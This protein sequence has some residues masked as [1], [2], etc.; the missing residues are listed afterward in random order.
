[1]RANA[2]LWLFFAVSNLF[3]Q[4]LGECFP[5][6]ATTP[7]RSTIYLLCENGIVLRRGETGDWETI[8]IPLASR[9]R[10]VHFVTPDR[11]FVTGDSGFAAETADGG[12][13]WRRMA[14]DTRENLT[15][16][17][18]I[19]DRIWIAGFGGVVFHSADDGKTWQ[20][21]RTFVTRPIE[22]LYFVDESRGWAVG[23][24]GLLLRTTDGGNSWQQVNV[25]GLWETLSAI[26]F[27]DHQ[28][29]WA[30]GMNGVMLRTRDG[31]ASWQR[32]PVATRSWLT[33]LDFG[34]DG[35]AWVAAEYQLLRSDDAGETWQVLPHDSAMAVTRVVA[36]RDLVL[37]LGPGFLLTRSRDESSWLRT[38]LDDL[39]RPARPPS[40]EKAGV[41]TSGGPA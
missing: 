31:G 24:S 39:V 29:G 5:Q 35:T 37:G 30:V 12:K 34:P 19:G 23:W 28:N 17:Q 4:D 3:S 8:R 27:R 9:L 41:P 36:T 22:G 38:N 7:D 15:A 14:V 21:Q 40:R 2:F 33:S 26:R 25:P 11:G 10:A 16:V 13:T 6:G 1:M 32:Q 18:A 20:P